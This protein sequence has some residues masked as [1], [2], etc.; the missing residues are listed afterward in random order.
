VADTTTYPFTK[1]QNKC[2]S[3]G[4]KNLPEPI[5]FAQLS[6]LTNDYVCSQCYVNHNYTLACKSSSAVV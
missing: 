2:S 3:C 4:N 1:N 5:A 6:R